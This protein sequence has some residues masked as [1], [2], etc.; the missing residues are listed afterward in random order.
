MQILVTGST[1]FIGRRVIAQ[2]LKHGHSVKA[3]V[4]NR[5]RIPSDWGKNNIDIIYG[6]IM[7]VDSVR[8][9]CKNVDSI[10]HLVAVVREKGPATFKQINYLGTKNVI[11]AAKIEGV[12]QFIHASAIGASA[13][14]SIPYLY[15]RW[16][17]EQ[18]IIE[19]P[20]SYSILRFSVAFGRGDEFFNT[21][22]ALTK[23]SRIVPVAGSGKT[24]FQPISADDVARCL[25][26]SVLEN[27]D[28]DSIIELG[29]PENYTYNELLD[30]IASTLRIKIFKSHMPLNMISRLAFV[31]DKILI[32]A[33]VTPDQLKMLSI[34]N[35]ALIDSVE[36]N[37][38]FKPVGLKG[39]LDYLGE[40]KLFDALK[41]AAGFPK[42]RSKDY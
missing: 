36:T 37:F 13:N 21:L 27:R 6:D 26:A 1:G 38:G 5:S 31:M 41:I 23:I 40:L 22:A 32:K 18:H 34:D 35:I 12:K 17:A 15:S 11:N 29:G 19:N 30:L 33:P 9:A 42:T 28:I 16:L 20:I 7:D 25:V 10:I 24:L 2:L 39:N 3:L 8:L 14:K 4:R